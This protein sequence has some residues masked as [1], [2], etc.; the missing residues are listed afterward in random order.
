MKTLRAPDRR[1]LV[2]ALILLVG[3]RIG[4]RLMSFPAVRRR[5]EGRAAAELQPVDRLSWAAKA[6]GRRVPGTTCLAEALVVYGMLRHHGH[7]AEIRIGVRHGSSP[8]LEAHAWV[9][10]EGAVVMG[11]VEN[12]SE[13]AVLS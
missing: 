5:L 7:A 4:L 8:P 2:E 6:V 3:V 13:H 1:L 11:A 10:C 12:L 9:E